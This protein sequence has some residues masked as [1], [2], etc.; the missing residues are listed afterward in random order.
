MAITINRIVT[1][2]GLE[3]SLNVAGWGVGMVKTGSGVFMPADGEA[4][5]AEGNGSLGSSK[6]VGGA[7]RSGAT[8]SVKISVSLWTSGWVI[9]GS[10]GAGGMLGIGND[11]ALSLGISLNMPEI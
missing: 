7:D 10:V 8:G 9:S 6:V 2:G 5:L 1:I 4:S 11:P 3:L